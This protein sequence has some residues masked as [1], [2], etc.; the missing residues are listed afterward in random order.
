MASLLVAPSTFLAIG[1]MSDDGPIGRRGVFSPQRTIEAHWFNIERRRSFGG[2]NSP[3][4][5]Y[6]G[7]LGMVYFG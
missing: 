2:F 3:Y 6:F 1:P 4:P 7:S 5:R